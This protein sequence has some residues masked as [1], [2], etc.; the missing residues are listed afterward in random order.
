MLIAKLIWDVKACVVDVETAVLHGELQDEI[1]MNVPKDFTH[2]IQLLFKTIQDNLRT[3]TE[4][5][6]DYKKLISV[7]KLIGFEE[8]SLICVYSQNGSKMS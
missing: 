5:K 3:C 1:Y 7:L 4:C 8:N 6:R 2:W